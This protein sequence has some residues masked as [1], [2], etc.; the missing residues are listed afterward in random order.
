[1]SAAI[2]HRKNN[3]KGKGQFSAQEVSLHAT[4]QNHALWPPICFFLSILH[5]GCCSFQSA[6]DVAS[7]EKRA[8][9]GRDQKAKG[10]LLW[11]L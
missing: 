6:D 1:M 8:G 4:N 2:D 5:L 9:A 11:C 3:F 10:M 7:K